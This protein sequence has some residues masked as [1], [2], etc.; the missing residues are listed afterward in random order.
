MTMPP[1]SPETRVLR[2]LLADAHGR[3]RELEDQVDRLTEALLTPRF[4]DR[5]HRSEPH[6][7][8]RSGH[9]R[10]RALAGSG[11]PGSGGGRMSSRW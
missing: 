5:R 1:D 6:P 9:D 10:R 7:E 4:G 2:E 3:I 8:R 11:P